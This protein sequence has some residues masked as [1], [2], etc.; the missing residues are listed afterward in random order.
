MTRQE[1]L[2]SIG[3]MDNKLPQEFR[4]VVCEANLHGETGYFY[5]EQNKLKYIFINLHDLIDESVFLAML[6]T[7]PD[8]I[9]S[10]Q[11]GRWHSFYI[12]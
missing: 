8:F 5:F 10:I 9:D 1:F 7:Y 6:K 3:L 12:E 2:S 4:I 11:F